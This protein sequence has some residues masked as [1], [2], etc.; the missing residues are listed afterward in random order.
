M[1]LAVEERDYLVSLLNDDQLSYLEKERDNYTRVLWIELLCRIR[2]IKMPKSSD[3]DTLLKTL[4]EFVYTHR[5]TGPPGKTPFKC[6]KCGRHL[7]YQYHLKHSTSG[8][9]M[10]L[11]IECFKHVLALD[12]HV[13]LD[14]HKEV[15][16]GE[17]LFMDY[18]IAFREKDLVRYL[19]IMDIEEAPLVYKH[20]IGLGLPLTKK[21]EIDFER[22]Y[23]DYVYDQ[24][25]SDYEAYKKSVFNEA[26]LSYIKGLT[27][28]N[29]D[30]LMRQRIHDYA[31]VHYDAISVLDVGDDAKLRSKLGLPLTNRQLSNYNGKRAVYEDAQ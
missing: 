31:Y 4:N 27:K 13:S 26:Q 12:D 28:R 30:R 16:K 18:L 14:L 6:Q 11:G 23:R 24:E 19:P 3:Q 5:L 21:Q 15:N 9:V 8:V 1:N 2:G 10:K 20:Q 17:R 7:R 25:M 22:W 29:E